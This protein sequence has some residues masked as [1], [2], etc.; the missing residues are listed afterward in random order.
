MPV[1]KLPDGNLV[2]I[3]DDATQEQLLKL[4]DMYAPKQEM[5]T[6]VQLEG[7]GQEAP[8]I[9]QAARQLVSPE[10]SAKAM[11]IVKPIDT[12]LRKGLLFLPTLGHDTGKTIGKLLQQKLGI[13][14][15][16]GEFADK[17]R[18]IRGKVDKYLHPE[19]SKDPTAKIA[20]NL[21]ASIVTGKLI[22]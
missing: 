3:P 20:E 21:T 8:L 10:M 22:A 19:E 5:S 18:E 15:M 13:E 1:V 14:P 4:R 11:E 9:K 7:D 16:Q 2:N 17:V 12:G 6:P